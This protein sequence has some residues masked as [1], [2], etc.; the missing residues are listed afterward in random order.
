M[1]GAPLLGDRATGSLYCSTSNKFCLLPSEHNSKLHCS[2]TTERFHLPQVQK[3]RNSVTRHTNFERMK[4][5]SD[6]EIS[7]CRS[8]GRS[9][10][11]INSD[12]PHRLGFSSCQ[13]CGGH[14][15]IHH[16]HWSCPP[17][18]RS[19]HCP[20]LTSPLSSGSRRSSLTLRQK[21]P[22]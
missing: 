15:H 4:H 20:S 12:P 2:H 5:V 14:S 10:R 18:T 19:L 21:T 16:T 1:V 6:I 11:P 17:A 22:L 9:H 7:E 8:L 3:G 13:V